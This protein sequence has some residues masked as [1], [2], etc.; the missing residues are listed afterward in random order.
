MAS[1]EAWLKTLNLENYVST[2]KAA[3]FTEISLCHNLDDITLQNIGIQ[4]PGHRKRILSHLPREYVNL[5]QVSGDVEGHETEAVYSNVPET[6]APPILPPKKRS[7]VE[8]PLTAPKVVSRPVPQPRHRASSRK[9]SG[10][11]KKSFLSD[12]VQSPKETVP[13]DD[14][15]LTKSEDAVGS[16]YANTQ[17]VKTQMPSGGLTESPLEGTTVNFGTSALGE[18]KLSEPPK[19]KPRPRPRPYKS[20]DSSA[21]TPAGQ[22][23]KEQNNMADI[24]PIHNKT[25]VVPAA[26]MADTTCVQNNGNDRHSDSTTTPRVSD[27]IYQNTE[28]GPDISALSDFLETENRKSNSSFGS[29]SA[30]RGSV[31]IESLRA[32]LEDLDALIP[33]DDESSPTK[34]GALTGPE[35]LDQVPPSPR[36][37]RA[38]SNKFKPM[39]KPPDA[40]IT[41]MFDPFRRVSSEKKELSPLAIKSN[42]LDV[43]ISSST[44]I[45]PPK[46]QDKSAT[47]TSNYEAIWPSNRL[48]GMVLSKNKSSAGDL[49]SMDSPLES[50]KDILSGSNQLPQALNLETPP[51]SRDSTLSFTCP[52]P[53]FSPP[54]LP[55]MVAPPIPP[56]AGPPDFPAPSLPPTDKPPTFQ[57][58]LLP[59]FE[60]SNQTFEANFAD[61]DAFNNK[62][63]PVPRS[64]PHKD[65]DVFN[66]DLE[67]NFETTASSQPLPSNADADAWKRGSLQ[68]RPLTEDVGIYHDENFFDHS[69]NQNP[70]VRESV[71]NGNVYCDVAPPTTSQAT[72]G[73]ESLSVEN[74]Y[75]D[76]PTNDSPAPAPV[77]RQPIRP[78]PLPPGPRPS[79]VNKPFMGTR[80]LPPLPSMPRPPAPHAMP[81]DSAIY[82]LQGEVDSHAEVNESEDSLSDGGEIYSAVEETTTL[83]P[84]DPAEMSSRIPITPTSPVRRTERQGM[85]YKQGGK[86]GN[87]GWRKRWVVF[88]GKDIRYYEDQKSK[89]SKR[90]IPM[91]VMKNVEND[92][93]PGESKQYRF[94]LFTLDRVFIFAAEDLDDLT[95][96]SS[97]LLQ[98]IIKYKDVECNM[99]IPGGDMAGP[100]KEGFL[101]MDGTKGKCYIAIKG[102]KLCYYNNYDDFKV[103]SP[104][105][106]I[107]MQLASVKDAGKNKIQLITNYH[108][109]LFTCDSVQDFQQ[110]REAME[111]AIA[112]GLSDDT[113]LKQVYE[114]RSNKQCA[115]CSAPE[116]HWASINL[117]ITLCKSCSGVHRHLGTSISKVRSLRMDHKVW[118]T[119]LVKMFQAIGNDNSNDFWEWK[120]PLEDKLEPDVDTQTRQTF[121]MSKYQSKMYCKDHALQGKQES[122]NESLC[123]SVQRDDIMETVSLLFHGAETTHES[124]CIY[125]GTPSLTPVQLAK[126]AKQTVQLEFLYQNG[127]DGMNGSGSGSFSGASVSRRNIS[128]KG[129][130]YKTGSNQKEFLKRWCVLE[131]GTLSY[132]ADQKA[133]VAKDTIE[134]KDIMSVN[135]T[136]NEKYEH[137]FEVCTTKSGG[138]VYLFAT[139]SEEEIAEWITNIAKSCVPYT[140]IDEVQPF[141]AAGWMFIREGATGDWRKTWI[142]LKERQLALFV[143]HERESSYVDLRKA[144][145][146]KEQEGTCN[147]SYENGMMFVVDWPGRALYF[148]ADMK[149]DTESWWKIIH[150][151]ATESGPK[152]DE[153]QLTQEDI[154][155]IV[156]KCIKF[157]SAHGTT[158]EGIYRLNGTHSKVAHLLE[159]FRE[160][161][162]SVHLKADDYSVHDV[163]NALKRYFRTLTAPLLTRDLYPKFVETAA[164]QDHNSKLQWYKYHLGQLPKV[165]FNTLKK[166]LLH[167]QIIAKNNAENK[168]TDVNLGS[169][170]GPALMTL[171]SD[172]TGQKYNTT[173]QEIATLVDMIRYY[174]WLFDVDKATKEKEEKIEEALEKMKKAQAP[175][176]QAGD[177]MIPI[178]IG[179]KS[180]TCHMVKVPASMTVEELLSEIMIVAKLRPGNW[181]IFEVICD[182]QLERPLH[183]SEKP[184]PVTF[185]WSHWGEEDGRNSYLC[186]KPNVIYEQLEQVFNPHISSFSEL[187]F[188]DKKRFNKFF[189]EFSQSNLSYYKDSKL[190]SPIGSWKV[191]DLTIYLGVEQKR[192]KEK[193]CFTFIEDNEKVVRSK[194]SP[195]FG[196]TVCCNSEDERLRW[197]AAMYYAQHPEG[198]YKEGASKEPV[199]LASPGSSSSLSSMGTEQDPKGS[200]KFSKA[201]SKVTTSF[202]FLK[203]N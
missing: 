54:P 157:I 65:L 96:W 176:A 85:L 149:K 115:D 79:A 42:C 125:F 159:A 138:R 161:A 62:P 121:I 148:Q 71:N 194:D 38:A 124:S 168:M 192:S 53:S 175:Q 9:S 40:D 144:V 128:F 35:L 116:P 63:K 26:N 139:D 178:Y 44:Q 104:I 177:F 120:L 123:R 80:V 147:E 76:L 3:G 90:I 184:L 117:G 170:F 156:D 91:A 195:F 29:S 20:F 81:D 185:R 200:P 141:Y 101:K 22:E 66:T 56:R 102:D 132:F 163:A 133:I 51:G 196:K 64:R 112:E 114:N 70:S 129:Y 68:S 187:R 193:W 52:P 48:S 50:H 136:T 134:V 93:R 152:L 88:N 14:E 186:V 189:F 179:D 142:Q 155:V 69:Q 73:R 107:E 4:L 151:A 154:P 174:D 19:P 165:N 92:V 164:Y 181:G 74:V 37:V 72:G 28:I 97:T 21:S 106:E 47:Q 122:L 150:T 78:A 11:S 82:Q 198:L 41:D 10:S 36:L 190:G 30:I 167:L 113:V 119:S 18:R 162:R 5:S 108:S 57:A 202:R 15:A 95:Y 146:L 77:A 153:Q 137:S 166:L 109:F 34:L 23:T 172:H 110:W 173:Q 8:D 2:L 25:D 197:L 203:K 127:A 87:K 61:F 49:M 27:E 111:E 130:L 24:L 131:N 7:F 199:S 191:E 1:V 16:V 12:E 58:P 86:Q 160:D 6:E 140:A 89:V 100:D 182:G 105:H 84:F 43:P 45:N 67:A 31:G 13:E 59:A 143:E 158:T 201:F 94:K 171:D 33:S 60:T 46:S 145:G 98:A 180:G 17:N 135:R 32:R 183:F 188:S 103:A 39:T 55:T 99:L 75:T 126:L 169:I 83:K 118:S